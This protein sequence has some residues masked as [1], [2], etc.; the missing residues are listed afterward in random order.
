M[1]L[2]SQQS[3]FLLH[4]SQ[5]NATI[6]GAMIQDQSGRLISN[7][8]KN[9]PKARQAKASLIHLTWINSHQ[10]EGTL[11][12]RQGQ[13][14]TFLQEEQALCDSEPWGAGQS[15]PTTTWR[16]QR[17]PEALII[18]KRFYSQTP[19]ALWRENH[20]IGLII[21]VSQTFRNKTKYSQQRKIKLFTAS[22]CWGKW[23]SSFGSDDGDPSMLGV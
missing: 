10:N 15:P 7:Q 21:K 23:A 9:E 4:M 13:T 6:S 8:A 11:R 3:G 1:I 2:V 17:K 22:E 12:E 18:L 16:I 14:K 5:A 19:T 20:E